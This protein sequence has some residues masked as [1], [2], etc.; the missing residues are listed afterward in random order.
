MNDPYGIVHVDG[1]YHMFYQYVPEG[2]VWDA[3][4][5][6]GHAVSP[7]LV[8]WEEKAPA[9]TPTADEVGC[10]SGSVVFDERGP[11]LFYTR[12]SHGDWGR[13]M[14]VAAR[15]CS[16]LDDWE[17]TGDGVL[18]DGPPPG[19][20]GQEFI[21][22]RDPNVRRE[23]DR[24]VMIL[25]AGLKDRGGCV[26][27]YS[28]DDLVSWDY[29]GVLAR[30][31]EP[32]ATELDTGTIWECPQL[33]EVDGHWVLL[34]SVED[35]ASVSNV[36]YAIGDYDG[37]QF[38]ARTWGRFG[39]SRMVYATTAFRDRDGQACAVSWLRES[40]AKDQAPQGSPW[41]SAQ[42]LIH[43]L[44]VV[45][46][47]LVVGQHPALDAVLPSSPLSA[48]LSG[49]AAMPDIDGL[50][51]WRLSIDLDAQSTTGLTVQVAGADAAWAL[52]A[53]P[54]GRH[55]QVST[56]EAVLLD[57]PMPAESPSG[58]LDVVVDA[59]IVEVTWSAGEGVYAARVPVIARPTVTVVGATHE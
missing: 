15:A 10:W 9:L 5:S 3:A 47:R 35:W 53:D 24:W 50:S 21:E 13:G 38:T 42:T 8:R 25:G 22:F 49:S 34:I 46:G 29:D 28:S 16:G 20:A 43:E 26:L 31:P 59:D 51:P 58:M 1:S 45:D 27:Q 39:Y 30:R 36:V 23:G 55:L 57:A 37:R 6:W 2:T 56:P 52:R 48:Q 4:L 19:E 14:V 41:A 18:I 17:R 12:P 54:A 44:H 11:V 7:D 33:I 40:G 32:G